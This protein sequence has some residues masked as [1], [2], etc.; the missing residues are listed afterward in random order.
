MTLRAAIYARQSLD[1]DGAGLAVA[2]Q[3]EDC[4]QLAALRGWTV[5]ETFIDNDVSASSGKVRP[6]YERLRA[7]IRAGRIDA[8]TTWSADRLSRRPIEIEQLIDLVERHRTKLAMVSGEV[9]LSTPYGQAVA[10]IFAAIARQEVAMKGDRQA[11]ANRQRAEAGKVGWSVRPFGY[12]LDPDGR[13]VLVEAEAAL[14]KDAAARVLAGATVAS[15]V[16]HLN[17]SGH[18]TTRGGPWTTTT[19]KRLLVNPRLAGVAMYGGSPVASGEW[20]QLFDQET[21]ERL[22]MTLADPARRTAWT[23]EPKYL[24]SGLARCGICGGPTF[25]APMG[26]KGRRWMVLKC[27]VPHL[28]RRMDLVDELVEQVVLAR[29]KRPDVAAL[30]ADD[31]DVNALRAEAAELRQRRDD[32][33]AA[34]A[35]GLLTVAAV[36]EHGERL[37]TRLKAI[38]DQVALAA[39]DSSAL[40]TVVSAE[41]VEQAWQRLTL[42][43]RRE[44]IS[45]LCEVVILPAPHRGARFRPEDVRIDWRGGNG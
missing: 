25:A 30:L 27:R 17:A 13:I 38:E 7:A 14:L 33:A 4:R 2:R 23:T 12:D 32:L 34:L 18:R 1:R 31:V 3:I 45:L 19:V 6:A 36:R 41:H 22:V 35:E 40:A 15:V 10:R 44:I 29:I 24:L 26:P 28:V 37:R 9:D 16:R 5:T 43:E 8:V 20:P 42:A 21:H 39:G 11:R